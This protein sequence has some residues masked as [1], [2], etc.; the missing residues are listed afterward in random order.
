M[1][2]GVLDKGDQHPPARLTPIRVHRA[3]VHAGLNKLKDQTKEIR[4]TQKKTALCS[5][6]THF[7]ICTHLHPSHWKSHL[8]KGPRSTRFAFWGHLK[9]DQ[10]G[11]TGRSKMSTRFGQV[12]STTA[13]RYIPLPL[14]S[15]PRLSW[16]SGRSNSWRKAIG[17]TEASDSSDVWAEGVDA[18]AK[19]WSL[20]ATWKP[21]D[22]GDGIWTLQRENQQPTLSRSAPGSNTR[23]AFRQSKRH[24]AFGIL[25][26]DLG[27][28]QTR[29][30]EV[31]KDSG[32]SFPKRTSRSGSQLLPTVQPSK[33]ARR[34]P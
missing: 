5:S 7:T 16:F 13:Y 15:L 31:I 20:W 23:P 9:M 29:H 8:P 17:I 24:Q 18:L 28:T 33:R 27:L 1:P 25:T 10:T 11:E 26:L 3:C 21:P 6:S 14:P 22:L 4:S 30:A 32:S 2:R 19:T 12:S 34:N